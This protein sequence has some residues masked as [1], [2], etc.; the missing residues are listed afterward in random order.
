ME[1]K[2]CKKAFDFK[3]QKAILRRIITSQ[4]VQIKYTKNGYRENIAQIQVDHF[5]NEMGIE[6]V[7]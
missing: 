6:N 5:S 2:N 1:F 3:K 4:D 7:K